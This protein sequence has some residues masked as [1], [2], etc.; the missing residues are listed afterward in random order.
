MRYLAK[1]IELFLDVEKCRG[2]GTCLEVCPHAVF[3]LE[4]KKARVAD[5][6]SCMECGACAKNCRFGAI[7]AKSGVGC[8]AAIINGVLRGGEASCDCGCAEDGRGKAAKCC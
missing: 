7:K 6:D 5:G 1:D 3:A 2:C 4:G 8:A